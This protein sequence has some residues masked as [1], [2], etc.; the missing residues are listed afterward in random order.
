M[1]FLCF[2]T[3][4]KT[5]HQCFGKTKKKQKKSNELVDTNKGDKRLGEKGKGKLQSDAHT[6]SSIVRDE[7]NYPVKRHRFSKVATAQLC[8]NVR[9]YSCFD[10][11]GADSQQ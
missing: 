1:M 10:C 11:C 8:G 2:E 9:T 6:L 4:S 3:A 7:H 5:F